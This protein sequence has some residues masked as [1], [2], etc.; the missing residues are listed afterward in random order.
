MITTYLGDGVYIRDDSGPLLAIYTSYGYG[1]TNV[2]FLDVDVA[3][4]LQEYL[5][6]WLE[7]NQ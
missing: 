2:I 4:A 1:E 6:I 5:Q 7:L 3:A